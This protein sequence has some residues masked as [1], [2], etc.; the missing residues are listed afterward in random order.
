MAVVYKITRNDGLEYI[1]ITQNIKTRIN[2]HRKS[3]RFLIGIQKVQ[4]LFESES[5]QLCE[6]EEVKMIELYDTYRSGLNMTLTGKGKNEDC[7]FN[8]YGL[9]ASAETR[10][11]ISE[12]NKGKI[13]WNRGKPHSSQTKKHLSEVRKGKRHSSKLTL[14]QVKI[15]KDEYNSFRMSFSDSNIVNGKNGRPIT[16]VV[17]FAKKY[18]IQYGITYTGLKNIL[19]GKSWNNV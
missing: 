18:Y 15:I 5:Y 7:K 10:R 17:A 4:I 11:K 6:I 13:P 9:T 2:E 1:G 16:S 8:T 14:E 19:I 12:A 3:E